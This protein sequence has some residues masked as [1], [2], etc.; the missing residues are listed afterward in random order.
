MGGLCHCFN[1][2]NLI[3]LAGNDENGGQSPRFSL[4][5]PGE[6]KNTNPTATRWVEIHHRGG[7]FSAVA[8][9]C[10]TWECLLT[11]MPYLPFEC[12]FVGIGHVKHIRQ[13]PKGGIYPRAKHTSGRDMEKKWQRIRT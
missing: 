12:I 3:S 4:F 9:F 13:S 11:S 5:S 6:A 1:H 8:I 2:I 10:Y 7:G